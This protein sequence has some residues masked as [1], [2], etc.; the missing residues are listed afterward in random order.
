M[1]YMNG[2]LPVSVEFKYVLAQT[3]AV[4][5]RSSGMGISEQ[6]RP[7]KNRTMTST[8]WLR[9]RRI[10]VLLTSNAHQAHQGK[11]FHPEYHRRI[12]GTQPYR[13]AIRASC[14]V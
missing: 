5:A 13:L 7:A 12:T 3:M 4:P 1:A 2:G 10:H 6:A 14:Q 11:G 9:R 8:L